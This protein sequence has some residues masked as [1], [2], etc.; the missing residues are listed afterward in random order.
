MRGG[1][2][3]GQRG[4]QR[5]WSGEVLLAFEVGLGKVG[6]GEVKGAVDPGVMQILWALEA[7]L[8]GLWVSAVHLLCARH[9]LGPG[10][11][12]RNSHD[13]LLSCSL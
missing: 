3:S 13:P 1:E 8:N 5:P 6:R 12:P 4:R 11:T 10:D 9:V 2:D 7:M